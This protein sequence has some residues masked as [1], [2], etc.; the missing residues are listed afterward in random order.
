MF[1]MYGYLY[2]I[3]TALA[4]VVLAEPITGPKSPITT[5]EWEKTA[6]IQGASLITPINLNFIN[7]L[8]NQVHTQIRIGY[9]SIDVL[10]KSQ[11]KK[12]GTPFI[13]KVSYIALKIES[14][15]TN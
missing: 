12:Q 2:S 6:L 1:Q 5:R 14:H 10:N 7:Q 11:L 9:E 4:T 13:N 3:L 15:S 8:C